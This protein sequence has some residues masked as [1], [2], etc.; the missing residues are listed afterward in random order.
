MVINFKDWMK[1]QDKKTVELTKQKY[2]SQQMGFGKLFELNFIKVATG[3]ADNNPFLKVD[4]VSQ[5][6]DY[7][8]GADFKLSYKDEHDDT[9]NNMSIF[10]DITTNASKKYMITLVE[11]GYTLSNGCTV[12]IG[13]KLRNNYFKY[14]KPVMVLLLNSSKA[15]S[16]WFKEEDVLAIFFM[17]LQQVKYLSYTKTFSFNKEDKQGGG[18]RASELVDT[19]PGKKMWVI[20]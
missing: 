11:N 15:T 19:L 18:K 16:P 7:F 6:T 8:F 20:E 10:V 14:N 4:S 12:S 1:E 9:V 13:Y 2:E 5:E 17:A 3:L